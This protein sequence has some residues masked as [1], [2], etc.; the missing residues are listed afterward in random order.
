MGCIPFSHRTLSYKLT[1]P[2]PCSTHVDNQDTLQK[3]A[4]S[5]SF[6]VRIRSRRQAMG[7][8][9]ACFVYLSTL[10]SHICF[11]QNLNCTDKS[12]CLSCD[13]SGKLDMGTN[14]KYLCPYRQ[15]VTVGFLSS[16]C[17]PYLSHLPPSC[18]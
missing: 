16:S 2:R 5:F 13:C 11:A 17:M 8:S 6:R 1:V 9:L 7:S 4:N 12:L 15:T 18:F 10:L 3:R 14:M